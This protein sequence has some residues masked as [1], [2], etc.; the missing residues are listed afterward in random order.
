MKI[1]AYEVTQADGHD[2]A[3]VLDHIAGREYDAR[4]VDDTSSAMRLEALEHRDGLVIADFIKRRTHG[5]GHFQRDRALGGFDIDVRAGEGFAEETALV[6]DPETRFAVIQYNHHGP[7][8]YGIADYI[9]AADQRWLNQHRIVNPAFE[10]GVRLRPDGYER[11]RQMDIFRSVE[12]KISIPAVDQADRELGRSLSSVLRNPLGGVETVTIN[13]ATGLARD[14][15]LRASDVIGMMNE[16]MALG[17]AARRLVVKAK[18]T[19]AGAVEEI[20]LFDDRL[21]DDVSIEVGE[22]GR[23]PREIRWTL[24]MATYRRW[25]REG[26]L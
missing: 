25:R 10:L 5:P 12:A 1:H 11:L 2:L 7:R 6:F 8:A 26:A 21:E 24:L 13:Y 20:N 23:Y 3:A 14:S 22:D 17:G 18:Q 9:D 15:S 19:Q 16:V 4:F